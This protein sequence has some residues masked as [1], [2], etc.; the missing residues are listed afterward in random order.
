M[1][2]LL[3]KQPAKGTGIRKRRSKKKKPLIT[4]VR[5]KATRNGKSI[6]V[7]VCGEFHNRS[8]RF[9][10]IFTLGSFKPIKFDQNECQSGPSNQ[11]IL[12]EGSSKVVTEL[13]TDNGNNGSFS[14]TLRISDH[15]SRIKSCLFQTGN[16]SYTLTR[17]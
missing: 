4:N 2:K 17:N 10:F 9:P 1:L 15:Y 5:T 3:R 8:E 16:C 14:F 6:I 12:R 7:K 11:T 13:K